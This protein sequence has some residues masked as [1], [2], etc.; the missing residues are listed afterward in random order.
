MSVTY[1]LGD[2][3]AKRKAFRVEGEG[4]INLDNDEM[5][6][7]VRVADKTYYAVGT[8]PYGGM[9]V[10][11]YLAYC[12]CESDS[13]SQKRNKLFSL[14]LRF[15]KRMRSLSVVEYRAVQLLARFKP[16]AKEVFINLDGLEFSRTA[17]I[18]VKRLVRKMARFYRVFVAVS[19]Y[20]F[21]LGEE[22]LSLYS[23]DGSVT[24]V[25][26]G[27]LV[28]RRVKKKALGFV[29]PSPGEIAQLRPKKYTCSGRIKP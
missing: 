28:C 10:G 8:I 18:K 7:S 5:L 12:R 29:L 20:R 11:E 1:C 3:R 21:V 19:D 2:E 16:A 13:V 23:G 17:R 6:A 27:S 22:N 4:R 14:R 15:N 25:K 26:T 9:R 24:Q